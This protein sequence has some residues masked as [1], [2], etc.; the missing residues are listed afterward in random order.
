M[1]TQTEPDTFDAT[2]KE[3]MIKIYFFYLKPSCFSSHNEIKW[4]GL[5]GKFEILYQEIN[6]IM[7]NWITHISPPTSSVG[8][9]LNRRCSL[10]CRCTTPCGLK[11][12]KMCIGESWIPPWFCTVLKAE[13]LMWDLSTGA[14]KMG[15][16]QQCRWCW[17]ADLHWPQYP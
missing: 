16:S 10:P 11:L 7:N 4:L 6:K 14:V 5:N 13:D 3:K 17:W 2:W 1:M 15:S 8:Y 9:F 12:Q